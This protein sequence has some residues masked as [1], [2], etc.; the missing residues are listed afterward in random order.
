MNRQEQFE[1]GAYKVDERGYIDFGKCKP[2]RIQRRRIK[3]WRKPKGAI[4]VCRP[5]KYGNPFVIMSPVECEAAAAMGRK[6]YADSAED[7]VAKYKEWL[8]NAPDG[9]RIAEIAKSELRGHDLMCFCAVGSPCHADVLLQMA[10]EDQ[11]LTSVAD[12]GGPS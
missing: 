9:K 2:R 5:S 3:G 4:S 1:S 10:N 7:A 12:D 8:R 11:L 6:F